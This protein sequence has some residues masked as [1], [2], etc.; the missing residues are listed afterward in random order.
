MTKNSLGEIWPIKGH[1]FFGHS[2]WNSTSTASQLLDIRT[3]NRIR[4]S[5]ARN[6]PFWSTFRG[7]SFVT[8]NPDLRCLI[9]TSIPTPERLTSTLAL[10][11]STTW[12]A[13]LSFFLS[14]WIKI[15]RPR[16]KRAWTI[17]SLSYPPWK[18]LKA[19]TIREAKRFEYPVHSPW[20][21]IAARKCSVRFSRKETSEKHSTRL[22]FGRIADF[23]RGEREYFFGRGKNWKKR[24]YSQVHARSLTFPSS[25]D[26]RRSAEQRASSSA[27]S[28]R[29]ISPAIKMRVR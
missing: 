14:T 10:N 22:E 20:E 29:D 17:P 28:L 9:P 23:D 27:R 21:C 11:Y 3:S 25:S 24:I 15:T 26:E 16:S 4:W 8:E 1:V 18:K 12:S 19:G 5:G 6:A 13:L 2:L 7:R